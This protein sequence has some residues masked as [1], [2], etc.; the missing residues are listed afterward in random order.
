MRTASQNLTDNPS[1]NLPSRS[2][3]ILTCNRSSETSSQRSDLA[4]APIPRPTNPPAAPNAKAPMATHSAS[5]RGHNLSP[6][7]SSD[8]R[9]PR[10]APTPAPLTDP[11]TS[12]LMA[13]DFLPWLTSSLVTSVNE[14]V[15]GDA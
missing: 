10:T 3:T 2:D 4:R 9:R 15:R 11:R 12:P 6:F 1:A 5:G 7:G 14:I 8:A 13:C